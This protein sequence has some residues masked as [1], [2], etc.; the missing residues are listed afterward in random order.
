TYIDFTHFL[1][2][3]HSYF[4]ENDL[5]A[6]RPPEDLARFSGFFGKAVNGEIAETGLP[7]HADS[8]TYLM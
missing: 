2:D 4:V 8:H 1:E 7:Y 6:G 5:K 3:E